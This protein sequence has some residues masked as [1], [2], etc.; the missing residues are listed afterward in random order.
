MRLSLYS[1]LFV[2]IRAIRGKLFSSRLCVLVSLCEALFDYVKQKVI[3]C[4]REVI[5]KKF[6][7]DGQFKETLDGVIME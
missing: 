1:C 4:K 5:G 2:F 6:S 7:E 3:I